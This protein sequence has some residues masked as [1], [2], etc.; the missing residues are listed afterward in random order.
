MKILD[1]GT[2]YVDGIEIGEV[3]SV[4]IESNEAASADMGLDGEILPQHFKS[5]KFKGEEL[6]S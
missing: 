2:M 4:S 3:V 5:V 1:S 6:I